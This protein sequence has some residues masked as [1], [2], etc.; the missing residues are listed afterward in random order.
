MLG[1]TANIAG[2]LISLTD[3]CCIDMVQKSFWCH[4]DLNGDKSTLVDTEPMLTQIYVAIWHLSINTWSAYFPQIIQEHAGLIPVW[5]SAATNDE[6]V[7]RTAATPDE[8][9]V[10]HIVQCE[11]MATL[12]RSDSSW[13]RTK[14]HTYS[15]QHFASH[16]HEMNLHEIHIHPLARMSFKICFFLF[17]FH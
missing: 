15:R 6:V 14:W 16:F 2:G 10:A 9:R 11:L 5:A 17:K 3:D 4:G 13:F 8:I 7:Q 12:A 1:L